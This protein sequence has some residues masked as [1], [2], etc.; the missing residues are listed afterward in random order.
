MKQIIQNIKDGETSTIDMPY[1]AI[2]KNY[3]I[4]K[5]RVSLI[6]LGTEKMLLEFG[7][8]SYLGKAQQQPEKVQMVLDKLKTDGIASTYESIVSKLNQPLPLGYSNVGEVVEVGEG[9]EEFS[10]GDIVVSN[11]P[12]AEIC[13]VS[14]NLCAKVP[15]GVD[16]DSAAFV[17]IASIAL[18]G[19]R[20]AKP[21]IGENF[22]VMGAGLIGLLTIQILVAN[23]CRVLAYD[24][25]KE[26]LKLAKEY[27][28]DI[29]LLND[30][31]DPINAGLSYSGGNG[32]DGVMITATSKSND[33]IKNAAT[34]CRKRGRII[35]IGVVGM[36]LDRSDFYEKEIT[37]QV[38]CSYG[39]G[40]YDDNYE[41]KG[42]DY[43]YG[44]VRWT[45]QRNFL[46]ILE[47]MRTKKIDVSKLITAKI[48]FENYKEAYDL[49]SNK[50]ESLGLLLDYSSSKLNKS[51]SYKIQNI[52]IKP[53]DEPIVAVIGAGNYASRVL[54]P[55]L[56][57]KKVILHTLVTQGS[58]AGTLHAKKNGFIYTE[59]SIDNVLKNDEVNTIVIATR[60][61]THADLVS[62]AILANKN[63]FVEKP[64]TINRKGLDK[65]QKSLNEINLKGYNP[66]VMVGY[67]RRFSKFTRKIKTLIK[68]DNNP[69]SFIM[70]MNAGHIE[71]NHWTQDPKIGG[72]RIV[73]EACH[74]I[75]LMRYLS[76]SKIKHISSQFLEDDQ[77]QSYK[78]DT[79]I[80]SISFEDGSVGVINYFANGSPK[81]MKEVI[82]VFSNGKILKL[83]NFNSLTGYGF[84]KFK[85]MSSFKQDKGQNNCIDEFFKSIITGNE[86]ISINEIIEIADKTLESVGD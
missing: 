79:A 16:I 66:I 57:K 6:S 24:F 38:S 2:S 1:P 45:E 28:A 7:K 12:H 15:E 46:S 77:N 74:Y 27:G 17:V 80:I 19:V 37:F 67:N 23:G 54:I 4:I 63:V 10:V 36:N 69:K 73:G 21:N 49:I 75:D 83:E 41:K 3:L 53:T 76:G 81:Y 51:T 78:N 29:Y 71:S 18:Q 59:T 72:G 56:R 14:K 84:K 62:K 13:K 34:I 60:H 30:E 64:I 39:P 43:P 55:T 58:I 35:L 5:S 48:K 33:L 9:A 11:G 40:R 31:S 8:S 32:V 44:F 42:I 85:K 25:D 65:I 86:A 20:L 70:T 50:K 68:N 61:D 47:L 22:A 52:Q 26:K 82:E